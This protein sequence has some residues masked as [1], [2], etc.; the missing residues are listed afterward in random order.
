VKF[1]KINERVG[2]L[3]KKIISD[4][5]GPLQLPYLIGKLKAEHKIVVSSSL[6]RQYL[7]EKLCM[8]YRK[9]GV[10]GKHYDDHT[11]LLKR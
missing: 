8:T 11:N 2:F 4:C 6:L 9:L 1:G 5:Q 10:V 3:I 7:R